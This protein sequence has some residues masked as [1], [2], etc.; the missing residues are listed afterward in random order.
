M[1]IVPAVGSVFLLRRRRK[2]HRASG[3]H[4]A[5]YPYISIIIPVYNSEASLFGCVESIC[6][7]TYPTDRIRVFLVNNG[8]KDKSYEVY[9]QC[10]AAFPDLALQWM[11]SAQGKSRALNMALYNCTGKYII[12]IDSDGA[13]EPH[14]LTNLVTRFEENPDLNCLTGAVL[15]E[16]EMIKKYKRFFPR[17]LRELEFMEYA[18]AFLAGRSYASERD[19][20]YTLSGAFSSFRKS[21][22]LQSELYNTDTI[23]EDTHLTFQMR[24]LYGE[25]VEVCEDAIFFTD[26]IED[27]NKLYTQRQRWQRGSIEVAKMFVSHGF[28]A[29]RLISDV[30]VRTLMYDHTFAFPRM[31]WYLALLCLLFMNSAGKAIVISSAVI[32]ALYICVGY[33]YFFSSLYFLRVAPEVRAYY[34]SHWWTILLL[35]LFNLMVF[36]IRLAG[37]VNSI[38]TTS[39]WKTANLTQEWESFRDT[40]TLD[41]VRPAKLLRWFRKKLNRE[42]QRREASSVLPVGWYV[43]SGILLLLTA[44]LAITVRW[45]SSTYGI[46]LNELINTM[47]GNLQGTS[48]DVI[49]A[50]VKGCVLPT[51]GV[52]VLYILF[53]IFDRRRSRRS[54]RAGTVFS[55]H[56]PSI[57]S[58]LLICSVLYANL[59]F[60]VL[61]YYQTKNSYSS[62]YEESYIDPNS[63]AIT[64]GEQQKNLIYIYLESMETT[65]ASVDD[66]GAQ[67]VNYIPQLTQLAQENTSFSNTEQLGGYHTVTGA[68][69]TMAALFTTTT[70]VPYAFPNDSTSMTEEETFASGITGLGDILAEQGYTQEFLCGSDAVF[71]GRELYFQTHG[72]YEIFDLYTA[73][74]QGYIPE[75]YFVWWGYEDSTLFDIAQDEVT[76]LAESGEPFNLTMLTVDLHHIAGY[77][78]DRCGSAYDTDTANVAACTDEL[79]AEFV[80]WC[81]QQPFYEDTVIVI[82]G[83]HP[84]MDTY[85]VDGLSYYDRTVYNCFINSAVETDN[86]TNREFTHMDIFPTVL[87]A[88]GYE[89]E[90][91]RLGLGTNLFSDKLTLAE[92]MGFDLLNT[93][94]SKSSDYYVATF[95]PELVK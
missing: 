22:V 9:T 32:L 35:P 67:Q 92:E 85:L 88:M 8:S 38:G 30:N 24:Y 45:V 26:P 14:A 59:Q 53:V 42:P 7:S 61:S 80:A 95:A 91:D 72:D 6:R 79:V 18:Q 76:R 19:A 62:I 47:T 13:L 51:V 73:R 71:G 33:F 93:E 65:Y 90:G 86:L 94:V 78:C 57:C 25:R 46:S 69:Y 15:I 5:Y 40:V 75:D 81:Q 41:F 16:P 44:A 70:G 29:R 10:Q 64:A 12:N 43:I 36:F 60:D 89:I 54:G 52:I 50:V 48:T 84:R 31:I 66:G 27:V 55:R 74:E 49:L 56:L 82:T 28:K 20:V 87:A 68:G 11:D 63:V 17:L 1:E 37:I 23:C 39:A 21:A 77:I 58:I 83:D 3:K 4:L 2:Q 34:K